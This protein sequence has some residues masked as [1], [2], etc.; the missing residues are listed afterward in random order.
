MLEF[1]LQVGRIV[2]LVAT[3]QFGT[4]RFKAKAACRVVVL[5]KQPPV[6]VVR[7]GTSLP[8]FEILR[9]NL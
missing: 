2:D 4:V 1:A 6:F 5:F 8:E 7:T 9:K 3:V